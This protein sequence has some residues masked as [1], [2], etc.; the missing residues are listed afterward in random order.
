MIF[1]IVTKVGF[2]ARVASYYWRKYN[3][4]NIPVL[5]AIDQHSFKQRQGMEIEMVPGRDINTSRV[6]S[7][8]F[9]FIGTD[10]FQQLIATVV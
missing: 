1:Y 9:T 7:A 10:I 3:A 4:H 2:T 5:F 6:F 8:V